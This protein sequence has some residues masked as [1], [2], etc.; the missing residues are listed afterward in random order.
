MKDRQEGVRKGMSH[1]TMF[2]VSVIESLQKQG[3]GGEVDSGLWL[4]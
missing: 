4:A 2:P 3:Q 1:L